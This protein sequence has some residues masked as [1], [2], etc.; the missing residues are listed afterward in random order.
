MKERRFNTVLFPLLRTLQQLRGSSTRHTPRPGCSY[1]RSTIEA[2]AERGCSIEFPGEVRKR[3]VTTAPTAAEADSGVVAGGEKNGNGLPMGWER[4][5][6]R[7]RLTRANYPCTD[8]PA[9]GQ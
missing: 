6:G 2:K 4:D 3:T 9:D 7:G 8:Q 5:A 1:L